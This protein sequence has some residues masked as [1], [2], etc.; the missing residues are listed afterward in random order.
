M[1][2]IAG[3][4]YKLKYSDSFC[5]AYTYEEGKLAKIIR[6]KE[7]IDVTFVGEINTRNGDRNIF[8]SEDYAGYIMYST[9]RL[10]SYILDKKQIEIE[11]IKKQIKVLQGKLKKIKNGES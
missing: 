9:G 6:S 4:K 3:E 7:I 2:L 11:E 10:S 8:Y 5:H 1:K